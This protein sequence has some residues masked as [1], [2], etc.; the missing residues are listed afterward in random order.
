M[1]EKGN[2][3]KHRYSYSGG[4]KAVETEK[5]GF[6][7]ARDRYGEPKYFRGAPSPKDTSRPQDPVDKQGPGNDVPENSWLR[8]G[9]KGGEGKPGYVPGFK[10]KG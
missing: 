3:D 7:K 5:W 10:G 1:V 9:G 4:V 6:N 8:G 2:V